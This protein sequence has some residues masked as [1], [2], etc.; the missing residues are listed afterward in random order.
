MHLAG[1]AA[2]GT[3][4]PAAA[5]RPLFRAPGP[6]PAPCGSGLAA[7][8]VAAHLR[9]IVAVDEP[10]VDRIVVGTGCF[11]DPIEFMDLR[12][13]LFIALDDIVRTRTQTVF[14]RDTGYPLVVVNHGTSEEAGVH[15]LAEHLKAAYP[16]RKIVHYPQGCGYEWVT[17]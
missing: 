10:S 12:P 15:L 5:A 6:A 11:C 8:D 3:V 7:K 14:A 9:S 1:L 17:G 4:I 2:A 13:D 16:G